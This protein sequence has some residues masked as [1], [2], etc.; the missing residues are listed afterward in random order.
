MTPNDN[1]LCYLKPNVA[2]EPLIDG[3]FAWPQLIFPPTYALNLANRH[4]RLME[5]YLAAPD[6]HRDAAEDPTMLGGPFLDFE[7]ASRADDVRA[8]LID[9]KEKRHLAFELAEAITELGA[10]LAR[11]ARGGPLELLYEKVPELLKGYVELHYDLGDRPSFRYFEQLLYRSRFNQTAAQSVALRALTD[12]QRPF[13]LSTPRLPTVDS[14]HLGTTFKSEELATLLRSRD[15]PVPRGALREMLRVPEDR[16]AVFN[17][18]VTGEKQ[19]PAP[20]YAEGRV[21]TRYFGHGTVL[22]EAPGVSILTDPLLSYDYGE[23]GS[24]YVFSDLPAEI[25]FLLITHAHPDHAIPEFLL[26]LRHRVKTVIVPR[27]AGG[28]LLDFSIKRVFQELGFT[29]VI[30]LDDMDS[31]PTAAGSIT[32]VPFMGEHGDLEIRSKAGYLVKAADKSIL[33][34]ADSCNLEPKLYRH[35]QREVGDVN[36]LFVGMECDGA[37]LTF[38]YGPL[39][40]EEPGRKQ[41]YARKLIGSDYGRV[42]DLVDCFRVR[43]VYV[44]AMGYEPWA[45]YILALRYDEQHRAVIESNRVVE[46][47]RARGLLAERLFGKKEMFH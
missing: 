24:R 10:L 12:D 7:G 28:T 41:N 21:K 13:V 4:V 27:A 14:V 33:F 8:L 36:V 26:Q 6:A 15:E 44:Y 43:E 45:T 30:E 2:V 32:S 42:M 23:K 1:D 9:T 29:S 16:K 25:D 35:V 31:V 19:R 34:L 11:E 18:F 22:V 20:R 47:C 38:F 5:S 17:A 40:P 3:W 46:A 39:R 37:P